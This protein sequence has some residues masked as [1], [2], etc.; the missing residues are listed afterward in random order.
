MKAVE[1][2]ATVPVPEKKIKVEQQVPYDPDVPREYQDLLRGAKADDWR[3]PQ[4]FLEIGR[5]HV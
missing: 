3:I 2:K 1:K 5:A 4:I